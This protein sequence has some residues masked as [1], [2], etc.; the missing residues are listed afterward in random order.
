MTKEVR[1]QVNSIIANLQEINDQI[2]ELHRLE[3]P[4]EKDYFERR[5]ELRTKIK[6]K[7]VVD[8]GA[9]CNSLDEVINRLENV[10]CR[11]ITD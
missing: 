7:N 2:W 1:E 11:E 6:G 9:A 4:H 3:E 10:T 8:F 5:E